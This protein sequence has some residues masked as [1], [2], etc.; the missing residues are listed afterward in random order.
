M[1]Q[2]IGSD[3]IIKRAFQV[4]DQAGWSEEELRTYEHIV[5]T[6]MDNAAVEEQK[7]EDAEVRGEAR[8]E[9]RGAKNQAKVI[10]KNLRSQ[11]FDIKFIAVSTGLTEEEVE[12][13]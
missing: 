9:A 5:K 1:E 12:G 13:L 3:M 6:N 4:I 7:I 11:G 10:A 8:G 2:L